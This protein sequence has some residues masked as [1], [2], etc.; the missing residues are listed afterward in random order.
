MSSSK[1][2]PKQKKSYGGIIGIVKRK[3]SKK[4]RQSPEFNGSSL[5]EASSLKE[6]ESHSETLDSSDQAREMATE[7]QAAQ[8]E[9]DAAE[10][11]IKQDE[12]TILA[13]Q[14]ELQKLRGE[15][16]ESHAKM[17]NITENL[18]GNQ[19]QE[20]QHKKEVGEL[21]E[22][23]NK[24]RNLEQQVR[25]LKEEIQDLQTQNQE[26]R[27]H[28]ERKST[29]SKMQSLSKEKSTKEEVQKLQKEL[30]MAERNLQ[31][32]TSHFEAQLKACQDGNERLQEKIKIT[33]RQYDEIEKEKLS[34][35][36]E[37]GRLLKKLES[38]GGF[39]EK[40]R[41][42]LE[43]ETA[44]L[45]LQNLKRKNQKLEKQLITISNQKLNLINYD[46][47]VEDQENLNGVSSTISRP[48]LSEARVISLE[49]EVRQLEMA[50]HKLKK[51][52]ESL[53]EKASS[54]EQTSEVFAL[55][56][57]QLDG[58]LQ[59]EKDKVEELDAEFNKLK[60]VTAGELGEDHLSNML[61]QIQNL[62]TAMK[63]SE[64]KF[65]VKEKDLW[66]TIEA[67]KKQIQELE[68]EKLALELGEEEE[69]E[70]GN[71]TANHED[72]FTEKIKLL[73]QEIKT[74]T[75]DKQKLKE[76]LNASIEKLEAAAGKIE[77]GSSLQEEI[78]VT[79][80]KNEVLKAALEDS[81]AINAKYAIEVN[82]LQQEIASLKAQIKEY[83]IKTKNKETDSE[84]LVLLNNKID[85]L[86][87]ENEKL[88]LVI[89]ERDSDTTTSN[90][91]NSLEKEIERLKKEQA[92]LLIDLES[93][94]KE[95]DMRAEQSG[96][97]DQLKKEIE[98]LKD[99]NKK[100]QTDLDGAEDELEKMDAELIE[101]TKLLQKQIT[102]LTEENAK[103]LEKENKA[104]S[105]KIIVQYFIFPV[106][107][108]PT[109]GIS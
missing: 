87:K 52:N 65:H 20:L 100:L 26:L 75:I 68:M 16:D 94:E 98:K 74:L 14:S 45:E 77:L 24:R 54:C 91:I 59:K 92:Q 90:M 10:A 4:R 106:L 35:K 38:S 9:L 23:S 1:K 67:Q 43:Q 7:L 85:K 46:G 63:E 102:K 48:T 53:T 95:L 28:E 88:Q 101:Q 49:K 18:D 93:A 78:E 27:F 12:Q 25:Q 40:K 41:L 5:S 73:Q 30:R 72:E 81:E 47:E 57:K 37:N 97:A 8:D 108:V 6:A 3:T 13:L 83:A 29:Q 22:A 84:Q 86:K 31:Y 21:Q 109:A 19:A 96:G 62:E 17:K 32:E 51:E 39:A 70:E 69:A 64:T 11:K 36:I 79:R 60:T 55:K 42:Q 58:Q 15:L 34:L 103:L 44:E 80:G 107:L 99:E 61:K 82:S 76:D 33:Q 66:S 2:E 105:V 104:V 71:S 89:R 56:V 50:V